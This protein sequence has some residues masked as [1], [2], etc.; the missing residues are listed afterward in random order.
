MKKKKSISPNTDSW[1]TPLFTYTPSD[2]FSVNY[3]SLCTFQKTVFYPFIKVFR[4]T[5]SFN[6][7]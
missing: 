2:V 6:F 3:D 1:E 5:M 7:T 4:Y